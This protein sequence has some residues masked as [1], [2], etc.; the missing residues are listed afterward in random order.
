MGEA[1]TVRLEAF[2][3]REGIYWERRHLLEEEA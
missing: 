3:G 1:F 2:T